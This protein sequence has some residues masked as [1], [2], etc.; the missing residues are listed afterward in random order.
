MALHDELY[1]AATSDS[2]GN[3]RFPLYTHAP[4]DADAAAPGSPFVHLLSLR[5]DR[6]IVA[7][8]WCADRPAGAEL[9][10]DFEPL[11]ATLPWP[12]GGAVATS[13]FVAKL[14]TGTFFETHAD[15][16]YRTKGV[17]TLRYRDVRDGTVVSEDHG[18]P[19][20]ERALLACLERPR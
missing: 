12:G 20:D 9:R 14:L 17:R 4:T 8:F 11:V 18:G 19:F 2:P 15:G 1:E 16:W 6:R 3:P 10:V 13:A 5:A 7:R